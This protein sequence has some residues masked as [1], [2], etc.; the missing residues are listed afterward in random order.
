MP[1]PRRRGRAL[2]SLRLPLLLLILAVP[3]CTRDNYRDWADLQVYSILADQTIETIEYQPDY[4]VGDGGEMPARAEIK[5]M[6]QRTPATP[7]SPPSVSPIEIRKIEYDFGPLGPDSRLKDA[8]PPEE[9]VSAVEISQTK[10]KAQRR[11]GPPAPGDMPLRLDL[12]GSIEYAVQHSRAYQDQLD[13]L[14]L[15]ALDLTLQRHLFDP[16]PSANVQARYNGNGSSGPLGYQAAMRVVDTVG[17]SQRLP[18]GGQLTAQG[19]H[20]LVETLSGQ[21]AEGSS[22]QLVLRGS[23][24]L[25]KGFGMVNLEPLIQSERSLIYQIRNFED[26]RR[27]FVVNIASSFFRLQSLAQAVANR[28]LNLRNLDNLTQRTQALYDAGRISF[29]DVQRSM[30]SLIQ[31]QSSLLNSEEAYIAALDN[32]KIVLGMP[33]D[34]QFDV[35]E[36]ALEVN[37]PHMEEAEAIRLAETYRLDLQTARDRLDDARRTAENAA[38]GLLPNLTIDGSTSVG[39]SGNLEDI[40]LDHRTASY[41]LGMTLDAPLDQVADRNSYRRALITVDSRI[42][43]MM[44]LHDQIVAD[45]RQALRGIRLAEENYQIQLRG[46]DLAEKRLEF[47]T[48]RLRQGKSDSREVVDSQTSLLDAQDQAAVAYNN[49]QSRVLDFLRFTGTLRVD[50]EAGSIGR[51]MDRAKPS[52][53]PAIASATENNREG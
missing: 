51:A 19:V 25:L 34:E 21:A 37:V 3:A 39:N 42:R 16:I 1:C 47:S 30:Q 28:R 18:W 9:E 48:E 2:F 53:R 49:V 24:P 45:V 22:A 31:A 36:V 13:T 50:P 11:L 12:F 44:Q 8:R 26:Y 23:M 20:N 6:Y 43:S 40:Q 35:A 4:R 38:N 32:F 5:R 7:A 29:L 41:Q 14:Y 17:V 46:I 52:T 15:S 10:L 27:Q 33:V